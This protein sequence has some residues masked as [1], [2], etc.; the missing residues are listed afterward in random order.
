VQFF[1]F[2]S[3]HIWLQNFLDFDSQ[4]AAG[5]LVRHIARSK[6]VVPMSYLHWPAFFT[7]R[8]LTD[9]TI[10]LIG[11]RLPTII[12]ELLRA[13]LNLFPYSSLFIDARPSCVFA[14]QCSA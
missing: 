10:G 11:V 14:M 12:A 2:G 1:F 13:R 9:V 8:I 3:T 4:F 5:L 6:M 7:E